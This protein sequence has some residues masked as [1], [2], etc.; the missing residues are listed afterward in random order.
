MRDQT[1]AD[2][3]ADLPEMTRIAWRIR[4]P[5][6]CHPSLLLPHAPAAIP[7]C[8]GPSA[9]CSRAAAICRRHSRALAGMQH[10]HG[11]VQGK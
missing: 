4:G 11:A 1:F 3:V 6:K 5:W 10:S 2:V 8:S 9:C 7:Q